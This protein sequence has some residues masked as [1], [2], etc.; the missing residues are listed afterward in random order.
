MITVPGQKLLLRGMPFLH[1]VRESSCGLANCALSAFHVMD[2]HLQLGS[3][4]QKQYREGICLELVSCR[5][6]KERGF[7]CLELGVCV[8]LESDKF[9]F[10]EVVQR[11]DVEV[12]HL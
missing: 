8:N 7:V 1:A 5:E 3:Y 12:S 6:V 4:L 2:P 10:S 11:T 9:H